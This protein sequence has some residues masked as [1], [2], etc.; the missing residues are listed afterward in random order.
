MWDQSHITPL[1]P[2]RVRDHTV[3]WVAPVEQSRTFVEALRHRGGLLGGA[4]PGFASH[5]REFEQADPS[6]SPEPDKDGRPKIS[7]VRGSR[8]GGDDNRPRRVNRLWG[9]RV[10][11][12]P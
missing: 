7:E 12:G 1:G 8:R 6:R 5:V 10:S 3:P 2:E 4:A 9:Q 11:E